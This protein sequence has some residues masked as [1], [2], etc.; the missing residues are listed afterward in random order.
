[1][2]LIEINNLI[3]IELLWFHD[4]IL[5]FN[6]LTQVIFLIHFLVLS[7][8]IGLALEIKFHNLFQPAFYGVVPVL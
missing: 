8:N 7:L 2:K 5:G 1:L 4:Q 3:S 6:M